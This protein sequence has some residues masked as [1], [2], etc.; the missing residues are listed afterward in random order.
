MRI[1]WLGW[2][3]SY[4]PLRMQA[5]A[6]TRGIHLDTLQ[7]TDVVWNVDKNLIGAYSAGEN[8]VEKYDALIARTFHPYISEALTIARLFADAGKVVIDRSITDEGFVVSKMHD[9]ILMAQHSVP[10][11][12]TWQTFDAGVLQ[13]QIANLGYPCVLKGVHG[14]H[15]EHVHLAHNDI[16]VKQRLSGY[17]PGELMLQE[18]LPAHEDYRLL[19]VGYETLPVMVCRSPEPGDFRTNVGSG[20]TA[21][22]KYVDEYPGLAEL[23]SKSAIILRREF[24][25][26]DI[27]CHLGQPYVL[28]V[29]RRPTFENFENVTGFDVAGTFLQYIVHKISQSQ[30]SR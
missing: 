26:V 13:Q 30:Q 12:R 4:T 24:A 10:V 27:R 19:V 18:Y 21:V 3:D 7:I 9:Y 11:P 5:A 1:L 2:E 25:G 20:A 14:S 8:L 17:P 23:A 28:E 29:N 16:E 15:G 6:A 22:A